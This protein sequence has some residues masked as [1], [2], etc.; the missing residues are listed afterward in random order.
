MIHVMLKRNISK[1]SSYLAYLNACEKI[2]S[3]HFLK[4][5]FIFLDYELI[6]VEI[7]SFITF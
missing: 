1:Q 6:T 2:I 3:E 7:F 5:D 4:A